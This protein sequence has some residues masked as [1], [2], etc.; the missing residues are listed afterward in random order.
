MT[1]RP[2]R[3]SRQLLTPEKTEA[4]LARGTHG[5]LSVLGEDGYPYAVPLSYV[6]ADGHLYFHCARAGHKIDALRACPKASFCVV[7]QDHV[8]PEEYTTYFRSAV[9]F[10]RANLVEDPA[11]MRR[12][13]DLIA[14]RYRP[15]FDQERAAAIDR[16]FPALAVIDFEIEHMTGKAAIE[17][18][19]AGE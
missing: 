19:R 1:F 13:V 7:D 17:L 12:I 15:G 8:V 2:M 4:I 14:L 10:G 5:V 3:R 18:I 9:C 6:Y 16:E 11:E